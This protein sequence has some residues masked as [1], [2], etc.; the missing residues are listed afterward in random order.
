MAGLRF[1][2]K[3]P[4]YFGVNRRRCSKQGSSTGQATVV[5]R[6][7]LVS[8]L[9]KMKR[10]GRCRDMHDVQCGDSPGYLARRIQ[11]MDES[12]SVR[13]NKNNGLW[14]RMPCTKSRLHDQYTRQKGGGAGFIR[15][16]GTEHGDT[17]DGLSQQRSGLQEATV[18]VKSRREDRDRKTL[19]HTG[20]LQR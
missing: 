8:A 18:D 19:L 11:R 3:Y 17:P 5:G 16:D 14:K 4:D 12:G 2:A 9:D 15:P 7:V 20:A 13:R 10:T 1:R 6:M